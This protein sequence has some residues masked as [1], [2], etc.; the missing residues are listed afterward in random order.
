MPIACST[1]TLRNVVAACCVA[2][3]LAAEAS[4]RS[5]RVRTSFSSVRPQITRLP[6]T[7][8]QP[9]HGCSRNAPK[10]NTGNHGASQNAITPGPV[11]NSRS[12]STSRR[13]CTWPLSGRRSMARCTALNTG[14]ATTS[15]N[16][17]PARTRT[18]VRTISS[19][20]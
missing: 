5:R 16:R 6:P 3:M 8:I 9:Y 11:R 18:R 15:S 13:V 17:M 14:C 12:V 20:P 1:S 10:T 4:A 19:N 7:A 2:V